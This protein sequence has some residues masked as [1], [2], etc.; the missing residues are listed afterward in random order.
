MEKLK[1]SLHMQR[2]QKRRKNKIIKKRL[3]NKMELGLILK[4]EQETNKKK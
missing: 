3:S 2:R 1:N 4:F